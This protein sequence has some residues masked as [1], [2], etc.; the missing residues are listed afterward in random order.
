MRKVGVGEDRAPQLVGAGIGTGGGVGVVDVLARRRRSGRAGRALG[1]VETTRAEEPE[2][3]PLVGVGADQE[4]HVGRGRRHASPRGGPAGATRRRPPVGRPS[5][6]TMPGRPAMRPRSWKT[7]PVTWML[8]ATSAAASAA[9]S[10]S[11]SVTPS[12]LIIDDVIS[13]ATFGAEGVGRG[14]ALGDRAVEQAPG[15]GQRQ[16]RRRRSW[17]PP[18]RR[19]W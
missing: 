6:A 2:E 11:R 12:R 16:Q 18:T 9:R 7:S 14:A 5:P 19:R 13:A 17:P 4:R 8:A 1:V 15:G 10:P 3:V